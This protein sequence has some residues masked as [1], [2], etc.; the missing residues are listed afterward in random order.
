MEDI[1][2]RGGADLWVEVSNIDAEDNRIDTD[3]ELSLDGV[4]EIVSAGARVILFPGQS[5]TIYRRLAHTFYGDQNAVE[6]TLVG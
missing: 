3:V 5:I 2:C 6:T 4:R 1:I